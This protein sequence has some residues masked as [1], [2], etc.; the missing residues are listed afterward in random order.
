MRLPDFSSRYAVLIATLITTLFSTTNASAD[1]TLQRGLY[2]RAMEAVKKDQFGQFSKFQSQLKN[3]SLFPIVKAKALRKTLPSQKSAAM[4][5]F[6]N[7]NLHAAEV[8]DL[9]IDWLKVLAKRKQWDSFL[10]LAPAV[11]ANRALECQRIRRRLKNV[12][13]EALQQEFSNVW[14]TG[15][16]LPDECDPLIASFQKAG[17]IQHDMIWNRIESVLRKGNIGLAKFLA[18]NYLNQSDRALVNGWIESLGNPTLA[19]K[20]A[21]HYQ[22]N[23][24]GQKIL[25]NAIKKIGRQN[26]KQALRIWEAN[27]ANTS[28]AMHN[29]MMEQIGLYGALDHLPE[30]QNWFNSV[31]AFS[32]SRA[33]AWRIR[34]NLRAQ[35]WN[36]VLSAINVLPE[37]E[38]RENVWRYWQA[39]SLT[40]LHKKEIA[41]PIYESLATQRDFYGFL[42]ADQ[43]SVPYDLNDR[44]LKVKEAQLSRVKN[45]R[46]MIM[47]RELFA[48]GETGKA[49]KQWNWAAKQFQGL[50]AA[51]AA[52]LAQQWGWYNRPIFA[53]SS[54]KAWDHL[55][56]RFPLAYENYVTSSAKKFGVDPSWIYGIIRQESAFLRDARSPAGALGLMQLMPTT[57]KHTGKRIGLT[58]SGRRS[59]LKTVNNINLGAAYIS[60]VSRQYDDNTALATAS[61]N[62]GPHRAK[63]WLPKSGTLPGDIWVETIPFTETR[64]YVKSV[65]TYAKV[66]DY[67][68]GVQGER[69]TKLLG[70][71]KPNY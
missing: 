12:Q 9:R 71:I 61:Y 43:L 24:I 63:K 15:K 46:G 54:I 42:A 52:I 13:A 21:A 48:L 11:V 6:I 7:Q 70:T 4:A 49:R 47:A 57:A 68:R 36:G 14:Q 30:S 38:K 59:I 32:D 3:Y 37:I 31:S 19:I 22:K 45:M 28:A 1:T 55:D 67:R 34:A 56:L 10:A 33:Q 27:A 50:D 65:M 2:K 16:S 5:K 60:T 35:D 25:L 8:E 64:R 53:L 29:K 23:E 39:R 17:L 41:K 58:V 62:A 40:A 26:P 69:V 18:E 66:Y 20:Q 44:K 51:A